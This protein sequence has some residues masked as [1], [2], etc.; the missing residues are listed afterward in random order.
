MSRL[1][2]RSPP[3]MMI[4]NAVIDA[5]LSVPTISFLVA[6]PVVARNHRHHHR[7]A[8]IVRLQSRRAPNDVERL[9]YPA[10]VCAIKSERSSGL[11]FAR[12]WNKSKTRICRWSDD[13]SALTGVSIPTVQIAAQKLI[14]AVR[15][16][17]HCLPT[18]SWFWVNYDRL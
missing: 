9:N 7:T 17:S 8:M 18:R 10:Y 5:P 12:T 4:S 16:Y 6:Q 13:T 1:A 3:A 14:A 2:P 11:S 15:P